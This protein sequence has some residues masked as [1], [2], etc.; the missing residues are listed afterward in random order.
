MLVGPIT[1]TPGEDEET[2]TQFWN[3]SGY[4]R[5]EGVLTDYTHN[6]QVTKGEV[7]DEMVEQFNQKYA[8]RLSQQERE[9]LVTWI[10][11]WAS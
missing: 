5:F 1:V 4:S 7:T 11:G 2:G 9:A 8:G 10:R 3:F 6:V